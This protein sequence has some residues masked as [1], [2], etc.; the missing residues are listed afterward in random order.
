MSWTEE[1]RSSSRG[2]RNVRL[3]DEEGFGALRKAQ[4]SGGDISTIP[5]LSTVNV[6]HAGAFNG[7]WINSEILAAFSS[8][9][10]AYIAFASKSKLLA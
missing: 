10:V 1:P 9:A 7:P 3:F 6:Y 2:S 4:R 5:A 8:V